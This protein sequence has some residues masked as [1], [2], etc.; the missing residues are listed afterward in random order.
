M[1]GQTLKVLAYVREG[2]KKPMKLLDDWLG[3]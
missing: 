1:V 3:K 2:V